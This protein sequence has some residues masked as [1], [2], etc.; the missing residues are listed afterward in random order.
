MKSNAREARARPTT[1]P[2]TGCDKAHDTV[3]LGAVRSAHRLG[4]GV[5][6]VHPTQFW[7]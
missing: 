7:T 5:Q 6:L 2:A 1:R 4:P 3:G